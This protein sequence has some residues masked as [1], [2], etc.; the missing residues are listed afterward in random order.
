MSKKDKT[1]KNKKG[2]VSMYLT[3][4]ILATIIIVITG[5]FAPMGVQFGTEM[6]LA[7]QDIL[8]TANDSIMQ[9]NNDTIRSS[10][11]SSV[12]AANSAASTNIEVNA[13]LFQYSWVFVII[14]T[15]LVLFLVTRRA[16]EYGY[17]GFI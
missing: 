17:G 10:I 6:F 11:L 8:D 7:G 13:N 5:V 14:I 9:I 1:M 3:F 12:S 16:V 4:I 15:A 2:A